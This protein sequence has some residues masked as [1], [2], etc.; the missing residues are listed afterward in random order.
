MTIKTKTISTHG[1]LDC[2]KTAQAALKALR[3]T[4]QDGLRLSRAARLTRE[5]KAALKYWARKTSE[6]VCSE[7]GRPRADV[8][9]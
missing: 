8:P 3:D 1:E 7:K 5:L 2:K 4:I 9:Q 6:K